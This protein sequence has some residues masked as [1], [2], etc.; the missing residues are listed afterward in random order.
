[1]RHK[2]PEKLDSWL[3]AC[4]AS[5][6]NALRTFA[7][8]IQQDVKAVRTALELPCWSNAQTEGQVTRLKFIKRMMYGRANFDL[9]RQR[10]LLAA[11]PRLMRESYQFGITPPVSPLDILWL[12]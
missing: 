12:S 10:V 5:S 4:A 3:E 11:C 8:G 2:R 6:V 9:L 1:M 7:A